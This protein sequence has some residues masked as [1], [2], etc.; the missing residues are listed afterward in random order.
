MIV[1]G[2]FTALYTYSIINFILQF[3]FT[4]KEGISYA[5][6]AYPIEWYLSFRVPLAGH[7]RQHSDTTRIFILR[8][9]IQI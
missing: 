7:G 6:L 9:V 2:G 8:T 5:E 1:K 4:Q 3:V